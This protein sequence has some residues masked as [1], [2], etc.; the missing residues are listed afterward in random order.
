MHP[1][2]RKGKA[3][4][5]HRGATLIEVLIAMLVFGIGIA[6]MLAM[7][8]NAVKEDF[9]SVQRSLGIW[10]GQEMID[11]IRL[12]PEATRDG[13]YLGLLADLDFDAF[14][15]APPARLCAD[16]Y[17]PVAGVVEDAESCNSTQMANFDAWQLACTSG[18]VAPE[19]SLTCD[20]ADTTDTVPCSRGSDLTLDLSWQARAVTDDTDIDD[21]DADL[22]TQRFRQVFRP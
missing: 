22:A 4:C 2:T 15:P 19:F 21:P 17:D 12:N 7:Q 1:R 3:T 9:D 13:T 14:C 18:L 6:G 11:R 16:H 10:V 20:D 8:L 5:R